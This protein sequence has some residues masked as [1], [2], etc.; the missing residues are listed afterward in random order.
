MH[1]CRWKCFSNIYLLSADH[2][3]AHHAIC[4]CMPKALL[5]SVPLPLQRHGETAACSPA[6]ATE[7]KKTWR[8]KTQDGLTPRSCP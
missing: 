2:K 6:E 7:H 3:L 8:G 1:I 4:H 5:Q